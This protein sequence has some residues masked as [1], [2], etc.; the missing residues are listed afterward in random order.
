MKMLIINASK[1]QS[2]FYLCVIYTFS[3]P[4]IRFFLVQTRE[5]FLTQV[6]SDNPVYALGLYL[7]EVILGT[8]WKKIT[9]AT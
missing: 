2:N 9:V 6:F 1:E 8:A 7:W 5:F 3:S 4:Q